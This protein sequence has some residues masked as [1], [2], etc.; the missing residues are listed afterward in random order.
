MQLQKLFPSG[1]LDNF[2]QLQLHELMV[3]EL[4]M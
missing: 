4:K 3:F 1:R 2:L